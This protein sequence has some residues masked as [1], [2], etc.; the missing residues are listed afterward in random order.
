M[1]G[2]VSSKKLTCYPMLL[3]VLIALL[4]GGATLAITIWAPWI[5]DVLGRHKTLAQA[6][7]FTA[8]YFAIYIYYLGRWQRQAAFWA[9]GLTIMAST[10]AGT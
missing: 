1:P 5:W 2:S 10:R 9:T 4:I 3:G 8:F 6:V 7:F